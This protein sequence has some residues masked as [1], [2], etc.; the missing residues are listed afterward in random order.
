MGSLNWMLRISR[1]IFMISQ[2]FHP[3]I[4]QLRN[5]FKIFRCSSFPIFLG[6][7]TNYLYS[8]KNSHILS[9]HY[10]PILSDFS[11]ILKFVVLHIFLVFVDSEFISLSGRALGESCTFIVPTLKSS[12]QHYVNLV[13]LQNIKYSFAMR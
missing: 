5:I 6:M 8:A 2:M 10:C 7:G 9:N 12:I 13:A 11:L 4:L 1:K 3:A